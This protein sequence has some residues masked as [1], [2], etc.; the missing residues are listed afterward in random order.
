I[1]KSLW[2]M[3]LALNLPNF[4]YIWLAV[5]K[6]ASPLSQ[7]IAEDKMAFLTFDPPA[8]LSPLLTTITDFII[9]IPAQVYNLFLLL[10]E[11]M[12]DPVGQVILV[13]QFGYG[14]GFSAYMVYLMFISQTTRRFQTSHYAIST[15]LM[16]L[17]AM[18]AGIASGYLQVFF[19]GS[20]GSPDAYAKF[21]TAVVICTIPGMI[22]LFFI[23]MKGEDIKE[24]QID[25]D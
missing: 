10:F 4:F 9:D 18:I 5:T 25:I 1:K 11:G 23:P 6:Q 19:A 13:D 24:A 2:P 3:V 22:T 16:A 17:G 20:E 14:F 7:K 15:G 21:F 8:G 12:R